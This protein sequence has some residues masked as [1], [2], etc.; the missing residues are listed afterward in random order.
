MTVP[1]CIAEYYKLAGGIFGRP[2]PIC[3]VHVGIVFINKFNT[4]K[5]ETTLRDVERRR[6][7]QP[8]DEEKTTTFKSDQH[9]C[10]T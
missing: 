8:N 4:D 10:K 3:E 2:R 7:A 1:D 5:L 6:S 9:L